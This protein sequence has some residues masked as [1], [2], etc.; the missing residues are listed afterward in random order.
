[1]PGRRASPFIGTNFG[2]RQALTVSLWVFGPQK[3]KNGV[4]SKEK[5]DSRDYDSAL[6]C[7]LTYNIQNVNLKAAVF[8]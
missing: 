6:M 1:M 7:I 5:T 3:K 8:D 2:M 4:E